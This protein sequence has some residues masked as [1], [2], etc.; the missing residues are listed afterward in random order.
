MLRG[1]TCSNGL[2]NDDARR[3]HLAKDVDDAATT[4]LGR[5]ESVVE[6]QLPK[7]HKHL[8][9]CGCTELLFCYPYENCYPR[10]DSIF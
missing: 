8:V 6:R 10:S 9:S 1:S 5:L 2:R 3:L 7:L 4:V